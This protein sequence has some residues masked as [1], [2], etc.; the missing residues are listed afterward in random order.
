MS[1]ANKDVARRTVYC[2]P[3]LLRRP[4]PRVIQAAGSSEAA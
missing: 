2:R 3:P 1:A 4:R